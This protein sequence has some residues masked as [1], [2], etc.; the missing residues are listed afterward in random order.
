MTYDQ[1]VKTARAKL[2]ASKKMHDDMKVQMSQLVDAIFYADLDVIYC[3]DR[4]DDVING[5]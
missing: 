4:L 1:K 2:K 3:R 5:D